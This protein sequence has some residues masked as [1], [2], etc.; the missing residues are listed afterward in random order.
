L[1]VPL[2]SAVG[3]SVTGLLLAIAL[4]LAALGGVM[5]FTITYDEM[6]HHLDHRR[7]VR[8]AAKAAVAAAVFLAVLTVL[9]GPVAAG[10]AR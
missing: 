5:A 6:E 2:G 10:R 9:A 3:D 1:R 8:E 4:P 7:A